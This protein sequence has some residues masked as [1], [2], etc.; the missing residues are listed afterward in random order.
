[1]LK[2]SYFHQPGNVAYSYE[3]IPERI[4]KLA[5]EKPDK[6]AMVMYL[7]KDERYEITRYV[8]FN[9]NGANV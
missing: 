4:Q 3:T 2:K 7:S 6:I 1:M 5:E 9:L 8:G